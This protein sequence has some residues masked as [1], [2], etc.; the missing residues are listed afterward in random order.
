MVGTV[1]LGGLSL[2]VVAVSLVALYEQ[3]LYTPEQREQARSLYRLRGFLWLLT[4]GLGVVSFGF[5]VTGETGLFLD[6]AFSVALLGLVLAF[7][8]RRFHRAIDTDRS[9]LTQRFEDWWS[10]PSDR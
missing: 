3:Q 10:H 4:A 2:L 9:P 8:E 1:I 6:Y 7:V 5:V